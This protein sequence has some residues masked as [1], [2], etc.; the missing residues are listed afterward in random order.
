[1]KLAV[2]IQ[3]YIRVVNHALH[4]PLMPLKDQNTGHL[5]PVSVTLGTYKG[6]TWQ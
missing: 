3:G 4:Q 2:A 6:Y 1:M 5:R